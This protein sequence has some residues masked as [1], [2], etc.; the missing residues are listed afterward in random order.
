[1][2]VRPLLFSVLVLST[3]LPAAAQER[4]H[5]TGR[6]Q[7]SDEIE[8]IGEITETSA[9]TGSDGKAVEAPQIDSRSKFRLSASTRAAYTSNAQL[10]GNHSSSDFLLSLIHI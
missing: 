9:E 8:D 1:M 6:A 10:S 2:S 5:Y 7:S 3:A 4:Y